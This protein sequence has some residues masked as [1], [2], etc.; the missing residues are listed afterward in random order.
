MINS[1]V[2]TMLSAL[3][4]N[5]FYDKYEAKKV[6]GKRLCHKDFLNY[7]IKLFYMDEK[8][9]LKQVGMMRKRYLSA[10]CLLFYALFDKHKLIVV[11]E[12]LREGVCLAGIKNIR[13]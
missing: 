3:K 2:P 5:M 13:F 10:G 8:I 4:Q 1:G 11:D 9:A 12:G 7:A 6:N